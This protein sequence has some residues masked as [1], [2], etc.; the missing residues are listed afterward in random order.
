MLEKSV[1][2]GIGLLVIRENK[3]LL[4]ERK[5]THG[6]GEYTG[7]GGHLEHLE[8]LEEAALRELAEEA[9]PD[10]KIKNIRFLSLM[11]CRH[12]KPQ[13]HICIGLLADW[14]GGEARVEEP[15][16]IGAWGWFELDKLPRRLF[17]PTA[18]FLKVY[19]SGRPDFAVD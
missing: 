15:D 5:N 11:N 9:G 16:Q 10:I 18:H 7:P 17:V 6:A 19:K 3:I 8:S 1:K 14:A 4:A 12:Y 13:H 2:V